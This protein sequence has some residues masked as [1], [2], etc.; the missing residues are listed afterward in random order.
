M[1]LTVRNLHTLEVSSLVREINV[2]AK[3]NSM[4]ELIIFL[5]KNKNVPYKVKKTVV[6]ACFNSSLLY[7]CEALLGVKSNRK[8]NTMLHESY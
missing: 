2:L 6:D 5:E 7:G 8:L 1:S 4:N 3:E